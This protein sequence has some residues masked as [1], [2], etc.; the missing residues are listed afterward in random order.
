L[1][2]SPTGHAHNSVTGNEQ[3]LATAGKLHTITIHDCTTGGTITVYDNTAESGTVIATLTLAAGEG[4]VS[5]HYDVA[6][7]SGL[8]IGYD[9][10]VVA[11]LTVSYSD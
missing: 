4:Y 3:I 8:Y 2:T 7:T 5:L 11:L 6:C 1:M 10:N 9:S